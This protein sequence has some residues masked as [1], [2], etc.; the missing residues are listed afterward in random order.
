MSSKSHSFKVKQMINATRTVVYNAY[1]DPEALK[2]WFSPSLEIQIEILKFNFEPGGDFRFRYTMEDGSK[3]VVGGCYTNI[4]PPCQ[5]A[6][7]WIWEEPDQHAGIPTLVVIQ[8]NEENGKTNVTIEH[9]HLP[10]LEACLRHKAGW[11]GT[12]GR[13]K[14]LF[15]DTKP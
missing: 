3:L 7:T 4:D 15:N 6:F 11:Q 10:S 13:L 14:S 8:F 1:S 2:N 9:K 5:L 12:L